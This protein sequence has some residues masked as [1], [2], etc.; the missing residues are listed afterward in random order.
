[1][2]G[3]MIILGIKKHGLVGSYFNQC[4]QYE[5]TVNEAENLNC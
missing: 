2:K 4:C 5:Q 1:M 3:V